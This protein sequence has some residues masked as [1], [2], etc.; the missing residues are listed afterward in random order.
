MIPHAPHAVLPAHPALVGRVGDEGVVLEP[1]APQRG[2]D[3]AHAVV[4]PAYL[5]RRALHRVAGV[6]ET[7]VGGL[8]R[9]HRLHGERLE[10]HAAVVLRMPVAGWILH[11]LP[12]HVGTVVGQEEKEGPVPVPLD[13][14]DALSR[15]EVRRVTRLH[16]HLAVLD[17]LLVVELLRVAVGLRHP[18]REAFRGREVRPEVPLAA[19]AADV[20]RVTQDL[21]EGGELAQRIVRLGTHHELR[22]EERVHAVLRGQE[23]RQERRARRR[24]HRVAAQRPREPHPFRGEPVDVRR[25]D[26]G[27]AVTPERPRA[28]V[29]G[30]DEDEVRRPR[31]SAGGDDQKEGGQPSE[32]SFLHGAG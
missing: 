28:L 24:T 11:Q 1:E 25:A 27:V 23:A 3:V 6:V 7:L 15:P 29:V 5:R 22:V 13:E 26:V 12:E 17:H 18:V 19:Q 30:E 32:V 31:G 10:L 14:L 4:D 8:P 2:E 20:T 16:P 21:P 9:V